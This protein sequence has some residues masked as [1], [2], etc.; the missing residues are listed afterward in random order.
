MLQIL[1]RKIHTFLRQPYFTQLWFMPVWILLGISKAAIFIMPFRHLV[2]YLGETV[3]I[4][5]QVPLLTPDQQIRAVQISR[6]VKL[7]A[8]YTP[9]DS[10][11][12]PQAI[13][14]CLLLK[15]YDI[16]YAL[17]FG[18]AR[19]SESSEFKAHAWVTAGRVGVTGGTSFGY[20]TVVGCFVSPPLLDNS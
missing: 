10:N 11:C 6:V 13:V 5:S 19:V 17:Y 20:Y 4:Q 1:Q 8:C 2:M 14:S 7:A 18:L 9:W 3:G 16:P 15:V 12:F